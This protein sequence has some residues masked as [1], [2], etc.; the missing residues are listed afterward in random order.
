MAE[1]NERARGLCG[2][3][4]EKVDEGGVS[5]FI[6]LKWNPKS[7]RVLMD[8]KG[9]RTKRLKQQTRWEGCLRMAIETKLN[10]EHHSGTYDWNEMGCAGIAGRN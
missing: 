2:R 5:Y 4:K 6:A 3:K 8:E 10:P 1:A 7:K 9:V